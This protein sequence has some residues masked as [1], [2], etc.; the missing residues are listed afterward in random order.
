MRRSH[1]ANN[2]FS[3]CLYSRKHEKCPFDC[4]KRR[5][6]QHA[7]QMDKCPPGCEMR[8]KEI[9]EKRV[10]LAEQLEKGN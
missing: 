1:Q 9:E 2:E 8:L 5:C 6:K 3:F 7:L 4:P 10:E